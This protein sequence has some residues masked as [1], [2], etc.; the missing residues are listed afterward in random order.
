MEQ[1]NK[2]QAGKIQKVQGSLQMN[3]EELF[4]LVDL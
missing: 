4:W 1:L 3:I 2:L